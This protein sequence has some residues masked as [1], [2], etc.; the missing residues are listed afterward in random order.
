MFFLAFLSG[1]FVNLLLFSADCNANN[2]FTIFA[3]DCDET[4][5]IVGPS[6][7][8]KPNFAKIDTADLTARLCNPITDLIE[9]LKDSVH[10]LPVL[11]YYQVNHDLTPVLRS[12]LVDVILNIEMRT[13]FE[14]L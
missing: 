12:T 7:I 9:I 10:G 3:I 4:M 6:C 2:A 8:N 5:S 1:D 13:N 11:H 14:L